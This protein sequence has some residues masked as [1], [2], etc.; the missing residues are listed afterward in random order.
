M[1]LAILVTPSFARAVN[2]L[3]SQDKTVRAYRLQLDK[4]APKALVSLAPQIICINY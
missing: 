1:A 2:E 3:G 4:L